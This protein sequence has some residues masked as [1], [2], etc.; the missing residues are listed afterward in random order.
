[1]ENRII[2]ESIR[3]FNELKEKFFNGN[4]EKKE[5]QCFVALIG[6]NNSFIRC[7]SSALNVETENIY[8]Y[9]NFS[10]FIKETPN[11]SNTSVKIIYDWNAIRNE[12]AR[13]L[14]DNGYTTEYP[15][16]LQ[17]HEVYAVVY[18]DA[19]NYYDCTTVVGYDL[20]NSENNIA[21]KKL[22]KKAIIN[23]G[24]SYYYSLKK[25]KYIAIIDRKYLTEI[26]ELLTKEWS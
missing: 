4:A 14:R 16:D 18:I 12:V 17:E 10:N 9:C 8:K 19:N 5:A 15:E 2:K 26:Q 13:C 20:E 22:D 3:C 1:M 24:L 21:Y 25:H 6:E 11:K 23:E 7:I